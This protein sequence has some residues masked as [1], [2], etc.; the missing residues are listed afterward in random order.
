MDPQPIVCFADMEAA[1]DAVTHLRLVLITLRQGLELAGRSD[2]YVSMAAP[3][4]SEIE[5]HL[6][7][8]RG[9]AER[10]GIP[11]PPR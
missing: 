8:I 6:E 2:L 5:Q 4:E 11:Q 7:A 10:S 3:A 9:F 1:W